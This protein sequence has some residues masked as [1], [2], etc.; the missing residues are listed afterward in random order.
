LRQSDPRALLHPL[1]PTLCTAWGWL[2][3]L[4]QPLPTAAQG[5]R[6]VPVGEKAVRP[7]PHEAAGEARHQAAAATFGGVEPQGLDTIA[8]TPVAVG[9]AA[10]AV[11]HGEE[12]VVRAGDA[13]R[14]AAARVQDV[15][16][17]SQGG[18]GGDDP[19][20]G[21]ELSVKLGKALR[22]GGTAP[23]APAWASAAQHLPR[24]T[25]LKARTGTRQRGAAAI[26]R[27]PWEASAPA[28]M[29]QWTWTC[30]PQV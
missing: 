20:F 18:L 6:L 29:T 19:L 2:G 25:V 26:Q 24:K 8:L 3:G 7:E 22:E 11:T 17:A 27:A 12:P 15:R 1:A 10:P 28:A 21:L 4:A 30:A 13:L 16:R 14:L 5:T 23:V 9:E